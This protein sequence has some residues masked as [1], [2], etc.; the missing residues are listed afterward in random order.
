M[1]GV[2]DIFMQSAHDDKLMIEFFDESGAIVTAESVSPAEES[3]RGSIEAALR[4]LKDHPH[5][6]LVVT[7]GDKRIAIPS[8]DIDSFVS[9]HQLPPKPAL[10]SMRRSAIT[11]AMLSVAAAASEFAPMPAII[12][13]GKHPHI[14]GN[15]CGR[16]NG[17]P[18]RQI[19]IRNS[20]CM[21]GSGKKAKKCCVYRPAG[22]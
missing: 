11:A 5:L 6:T 9:Q 3:S 2:E 18:A 22:K 7:H 1:F 8:K 15:I 14:G 4:T 19:Q 21:C 16:D 13:D 10:P 20:P 12:S 17:K